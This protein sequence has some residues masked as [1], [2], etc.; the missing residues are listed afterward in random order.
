MHW[1]ISRVETGL[2]RRGKRPDYGRPGQGLGIWT[3]VGGIRAGI[4]GSG[5]HVPVTRGR[6][7][8]GGGGGGDTGPAAVRCLEGC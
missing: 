8:G 2:E 3:W 4:G 6:P 1:G 5:P 7:V